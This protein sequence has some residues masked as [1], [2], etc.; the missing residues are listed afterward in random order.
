[1]TL[2]L[3][4]ERDRTS[5]QRAIDRAIPVVEARLA[6]YPD[7]QFGT[8]RA[9]LLAARASDDQELAASALDGI[10]RWT[11][12]WEPDLRDAELAEALDLVQ[13]AARAQRRERSR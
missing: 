11:I 2:P 10:L 8:L 13:Q 4:A 3:T 9:V 6:R 12:D 5:L 1:M 7:S